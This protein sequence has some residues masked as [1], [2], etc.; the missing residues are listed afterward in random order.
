MTEEIQKIYNS[1]RSPGKII[2][3]G[4]HSVLYGA[5]A[6]ACAVAKYTT[7]SFIP[8][9][10]ENQ[11]E[12]SINGEK[13]KPRPFGALKKLKNKLD[14]RF[15][16]FLEGNLPVRNILSRPDDLLL[17]SL[18]V[19][20]S[21]LPLPLPE[22]GRIESKSDI[23]LGA[24]MGSSAAA[25]AAML[26]LS[27]HLLDLPE[28]N[29]EKFFETVR[30]CER[31]QHGKGSALDAATVTFGGII[32]LNAAKPEKFATDKYANIEENFHTF[33]HGIPATSTGECVSFVRRH[34]AEDTALWRD[35]S[36]VCKEI[37]NLLKTENPQDENLISA[38]RENHRLLCKIGVV[39]EAA[40]NL[41]RKIEATGGAAKISGAGATL[42]ENAGMLLIYHQDENYLK[43]VIEKYQPEKI[44][45]LSRLQIAPT[46]AEI[47]P[48]SE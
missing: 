32:K 13:A 18:T 46:G 29:A 21:H 5:E 9:K 23:P 4:E 30:F 8:I 12:T 33:L 43:A 39:P 45:N 48:N 38:I 26:K 44:K 10:R 22:P 3:T 35:F 31:L 40:Q 25:V 20:A 42:G 37:C 41:I 1:A 19:A 24:G 34:F 7:V 16:L 47:I 15:E 11:L 6:L 27:L 14:K 17:Y 36:A 28:M 2:I